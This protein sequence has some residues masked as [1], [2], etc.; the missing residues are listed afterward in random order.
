[1]NLLLCHLPIPQTKMRHFAQAR[2]G[3]VFFV[4]YSRHWLVWV[5]KTK[6]IDSNLV[7]YYQHNLT[8]KCFKLI[9][10]Q[11]LAKPLYVKCESRLQCVLPESKHLPPLFFL[12]L[13]SNY[14]TAYG[15]QF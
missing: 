8:T 12:F 4:I 6:S 14:C 2:D 5:E 1:M 10:S 15:T 13:E 9:F 7:T 11:W 3:G